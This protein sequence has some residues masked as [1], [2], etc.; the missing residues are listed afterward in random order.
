GIQTSDKETAAK[1]TARKKKIKM[2]KQP[3]MISSIRAAEFRPTDMCLA[4]EL[5]E[6]L[7]RLADLQTVQKISGAEI[8]RYAAAQ[9]WVQEV[10]QEGRWR[11]LVTENGDREGFFLGK[12][13]S[14]HGTEYEVVFLS[15]V[16]Q[17]TVLEHYTDLILLSDEP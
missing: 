8:F 5:A 11:K 10:Y 1:D 4:T 17:Q 3:F 14:Q 12:K 2:Q 7:N 6:E 9:G 15:A 13:V 16:A